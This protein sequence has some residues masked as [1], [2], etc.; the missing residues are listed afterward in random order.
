MKRNKASKTLVVGGVP[1]LSLLPHDEVDRRDRKAL[2]MTWLRTFIVTFGLLLLATVTGLGWMFEAGAVQTSAA[3]ESSALQSEAAKYSEAAQTQ[4]EVQNLDKLRAQAGSNDLAWG[5]LIEEIKAV[6]PAGVVLTG[7][8]LAPGAAPKSGVAAS[9]QV[10]ITGTLT[11]SAS[12]TALQA[13][14]VT[15]LRAV[16]GFLS[17]DAGELSADGT[18]GKYTFSVTFSADQS[19]YTGRFGKVGG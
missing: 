8:K 19:R 6:S 12:N 10:G 5:S 13:E 4:S 9:A 2:R 7:F 18:A 3:Q 14:T 11:F 17:V 1:R 15:R 16:A